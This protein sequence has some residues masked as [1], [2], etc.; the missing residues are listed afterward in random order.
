MVLSSV[1]RYIDVLEETNKSLNE[2]ESNIYT[3]SQFVYKLLNID[4]YPKIDYYYKLLMTI[5]ELCNKLNKNGKH[6]NT[7]KINSHKGN[8]GNQMADKLAK[9]AANTAR[10][11]KF[12]DTKFLRYDLR[13]IQ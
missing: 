7:I 13:E 1:C 5:F 10:L 6:I 11:C 3:D 12:G 4:G 2:N 8:K 9:E